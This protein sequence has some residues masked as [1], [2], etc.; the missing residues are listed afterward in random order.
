MMRLSTGAKIG[1][2]LLAGTVIVGVAAAALAGDDEGSSSG[3]GSSGGSGSGDSG[4]TL[5]PRDGGGSGG[6]GSPRPS[7]PPNVSGDPKGFNTAMLGTPAKVRSAYETLGYSTPNASNLGPSTRSFQADYNAVSKAFAAGTLTLPNAP[8]VAELV[9]G[10]LAVD[11]DPGTN[12]LRA[13][14][15]ALLIKQS[16]ALWYP[17]V[18]QARAPGR[19]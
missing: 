3:S 10:T 1:L 14:E 11:G 15:I 7:P 12:T 2:G 9:R 13:L 16:G 5:P 17:L 19:A 8:A 4:T 18:T 6:G